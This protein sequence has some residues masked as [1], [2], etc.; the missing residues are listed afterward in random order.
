MKHTQHHTSHLLP[1]AIVV[2]VR[3]ERGAN[4]FL[5]VEGGQSAATVGEG[6]GSGGGGGTLRNRS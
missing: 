6:D 1:S 5:V 4:A 3:R 2:Y